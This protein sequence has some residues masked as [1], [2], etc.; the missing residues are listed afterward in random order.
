LTVEATP[1]GVRGVQAAAL[2]GHEV[3]GLTAPGAAIA[4]NW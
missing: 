1:D 2:Q 3:G 4:L